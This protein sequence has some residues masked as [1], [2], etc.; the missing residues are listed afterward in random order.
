MNETIIKTK[1]QVLESN[2]KYKTSGLN[3]ICEKSVDI[4]KLIVSNLI[5][6]PL[7]S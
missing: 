2:H 7:I 4:F 6:A 1:G 3:Y 5:S